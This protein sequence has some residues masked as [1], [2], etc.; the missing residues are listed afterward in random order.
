MTKGT[1]M[2][3]MLLVLLAEQSNMAGR[4]VATPEDLAGIPG[5][6]LFSR[7]FKWRPAIEP[8]TRDRPFVGTFGADG[9]KIVSGDPWDN[10]APVEGGQVRGVGP[11][12]TFGRLLLE[13][14]PGCTVGLIPA[15]VGGTPVAAWKPGGADP[16][17]TGRFPYDETVAMARE[18]M[19][20]GTIAAV[21]WHQGESDAA[22]GNPGYKAD[23][24]EVISNFRRDLNLDDSVPFLLGEL[25]SFYEPRIQEHAPAIDDAMYE[26]AEELPCVGV[27]G[28][29]DL[30]HR[31]DR[32]HF[33]TASAHRLGNRY[34]QEFRRMTACPEFKLFACSQAAIA[35]GPFQSRCDGMV[36]WVD[37]LHERFFRKQGGG[38]YEF[39]TFALGISRISA[40]S[41][42]A[43]GTF[44]LFASGCKVWNWRSGEAP[45]LF[46]ELPGHSHL[47]FNDVT[48]APDGSVFCTVL[49]D[50]YEN[51][52][53]ELW[54]LAPDGSFE[55]QNPFCRGIPN[56]MGFSPDRETFYFSASSE[57]IIYA[58]DYRSGALSNRRVFLDNV[59]PDGLAVD[60]EGG[61]WSAQWSEQL[62]RFNPDGTVSRDIFLPG[63]TVSSVCFGGESMRD[64]FIT[65]ANYPYRES[66]WFDRRAG[67]VMVWRNSPY[68]GMAIPFF[69]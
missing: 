57:H 58:W 32:L 59:N 25:G 29:K 21:L 47:Q 1:N 67:C 17:E 42:K 31:G 48:T 50:D 49:P 36:Y 53:G 45:V 5:L 13:A 20:S 46:T 38:P 62:T 65:T 3:N 28:C 24:R 44:L 34:F 60:T 14:N 39:E 12:R 30:T 27:V 4:D 2:N 33:D 19:K 68:T 16:W 22:C 41:Q 37:P 8:I 15:A 43:D 64:I 26:L 11:G 66:E 61:V 7:D 9:E 63:I 69:G 10:I 52:D 40:F 56:G 55:P 35:E 51:G 6:F 23:L 18:A 54:K